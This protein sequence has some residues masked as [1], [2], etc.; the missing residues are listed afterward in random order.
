MAQDTK[1]MRGEKPTVFTDLRK[2][3]GLEDVIS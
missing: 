2:S 1:R 3:K